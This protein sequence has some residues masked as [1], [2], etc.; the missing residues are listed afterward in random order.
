MAYGVRHGIDRT[1]TVLDSGVGHVGRAQP[2]Q[3]DHGRVDPRDS[4]ARTRSANAQATRLPSVTPSTDGRS[5]EL[6][7][8]RTPSF[9]RLHAHNGPRSTTINNIGRKSFGFT[10]D[11]VRMRGTMSRIPRKDPSYSVLD[12]IHLSQ[13]MRRGS[14]SV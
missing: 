3:H 12:A 10:A 14:I 7:L 13:R 4:L 5:G 6:Y 11:T 2:L 8:L 9:A 1:E